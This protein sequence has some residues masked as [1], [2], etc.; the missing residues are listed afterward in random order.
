VG[1]QTA[2]VSIPATLNALWDDAF[3]RIIPELPF[4]IWQDDS[5]TRVVSWKESIAISYC[6]AGFLLSRGIKRG[7]TLGV[8]STNNPAVLYI[9]LGARLL[10]AIPVMIPEDF[11][12]L[13]VS[14]V[15]QKTGMKMILV[16]DPD[17]YH[18]ALAALGANFQVKDIVTLF[19][20]EQVLVPGRTAIF[21]WLLDPGKVYWRENMPEIKALKAAVHE[22][23]VCSISWTR[24]ASGQLLSEIH[25][26][27]MIM[28]KLLSTE[29]SL[30]EM[31]EGTSLMPCVPFW[32]FENRLKG[33]YMPLH[34][35]MR[36]LI[37]HATASVENA[38]RDMKPEVI[39]ISSAQLN[40]LYERLTGKL[41]HKGWYA[42]RKYQDAL[43]AGAKYLQAL[44]NAQ[45]P[46]I[47]L[48]WKYTSGKKRLRK[49]VLKKLNP[50]LKAIL[51]CD[52]GVSEPAISLFLQLDVP[53][54]SPEGFRITQNNRGQVVSLNPIQNAFVHKIETRQE[55]PHETD[56]TESD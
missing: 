6:M 36:M 45:K 19:D 56:L 23:D 11:A 3:G 30:Q 33:F 40:G 27:Q 29:L 25:T 48:K 14:E 43:K 4:I 51:L 37:P 39:L 54:F 13:E 10:G 26:H 42:R 47:W 18:K 41:S 38:I 22:D 16:S 52:T 7:E 50:S 9:E 46:G 31:P 35:C 17:T 20:D 2:P 49:G 28:Q 24:D 15:A 1:K 12:T 34:R 55:E 5:K 53:V 21:N 32:V 8:F 44:D